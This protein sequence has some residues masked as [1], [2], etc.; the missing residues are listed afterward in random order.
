MKLRYLLLLLAAMLL[1]PLNAQKAFLFS[2]F[3]E[4]ADGLHLAYSYDGLTWKA[5]KQNKSLL[6]PMVGKDKLMRDPSICQG[7]DGTFHMVWTSSW[8]DQIIGYASSSDLIH[9]S[10]QKAIPVM[11]HKPTTRNSWAPE[12]FYDDSEKLFYIFW[13][14]T[15][16]GEEG[17][18]NNASE[19]NYN[20][21]IYCTTTKDFNTFS[22]TQLWFNPNFNCIDAA[23]VKHPHTGE[24]MMLVKN[25]SLHPEE[26]NIRVARG[27]SMKEGFCHQVSSP[28]HGNF[29]AE[30]PSPLYIDDNTLLVYFD[31]YMD[32]KYGVCKS[33]DHGK[34]WTD[35]TEQ[36]IVPSNIKHGTAFSVDK[37]VVDNLIATV[38]E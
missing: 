8:N 2:F 32:H 37:K 36:L 11:T 14:S 1:L 7:P 16:P 33:T 15:V 35:I 23:V 5:V 17:I 38:G 6:T 27:K 13:A 12:L 30:G 29:W 18:V 4:E 24:L 9:W 34:T 25:E 21:R 19:D 31:R 10:K 20:H 22:P 28:I 3:C 26:K